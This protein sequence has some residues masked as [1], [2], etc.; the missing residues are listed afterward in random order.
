MTM[1][2]QICKTRR[3]LLKTGMAFTLAGL[4]VRPAFAVVNPVNTGVREL[5]F[6]NLHTGESLKTAYW[7][8][9]EYLPEALVDIN[10]ILRDHRNNEVSPIEPRLLDLLL[11]LRG[12]LD[13]TQPI[14]IISGYRSP[15]TNAQLA[16]HTDGVAKD[17]LHMQGKAVDIQIERVSLLDLRSAAIAAQ[18]GG[19]GYYPSSNF[20]HVDVGRVRTW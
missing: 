15:A 11:V 12:K 3:R 2:N 20:V 14:Q 8:N 19:V 13:N 1:N 17:S 6:Y 7:E 16:A 5:D 10:R 9:G 18:G 4:G